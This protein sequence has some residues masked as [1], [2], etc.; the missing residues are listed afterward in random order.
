MSLDPSLSDPGDI[1]VP[2]LRNV[3]SGIILD[4]SNDLQE[5]LLNRRTIRLC[6]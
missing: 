6:G 5:P 4:D 2:L 3:S 1:G